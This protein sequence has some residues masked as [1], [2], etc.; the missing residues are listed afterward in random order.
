MKKKK[1]QKRTASEQTDMPEV[2]RMIVTN[3]ATATAT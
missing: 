2:N 3:T 1:I